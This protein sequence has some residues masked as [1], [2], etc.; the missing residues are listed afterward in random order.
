MKKLHLIETNIEEVYIIEPSIF[1]DNRGSF[2]EIYNKRDFEEIGITKDFVQDNQVVSKKGVLR[3]LHFQCK[4]PQAKLVK[5]MQGKVFD[6][7]VDLRDKSKTFGKWFGINLTEDSNR[8]LYIPE[9]FAHGYLVLSQKAVFNYKCTEYYHP[10]DQLGLIWNDP[11]I[12]IPWPLKEDEIILSDQDKNW[13][14][15][16]E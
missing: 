8:M 1:Y 11:S 6:V 7:A 10:E 12:N 14:K 2:T 4:Y 3:G 16:E 13:V 15:L 9:G 5:V